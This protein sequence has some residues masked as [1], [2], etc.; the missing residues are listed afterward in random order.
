MINYPSKIRQVLESNLPN[1]KKIELIEE[2]QIRHARVSFHAYRRYM[3]PDNKSG[4]FQRDV[5]DNLQQFYDEFVAG[6]RPKLVIEAPPQH[7]KSVQIVD[8]IAWLS[9]KLPDNKTIY[10]S[11][12]ERLGVRANLSM[13]RMMSTT[14]YKNVFPGTILPTRRQTHS[15]NPKIRDRNLIEYA[16]SLG[17]FRNTTVEGSI[18][19]ESLDL[20]VIDDPMRG[21][22]DANSITKRNSAWD[23]FTD[24]FFTRFSEHAGLL[25]ILTRWHVD[26]PIG[27][28]I[29]KNDDVKVLKYPALAT[30]DAK[31]MKHDPRKSG[32]DEALFPEHKSTEFLLER[33]KT[34]AS[35]NWSALYQQ[36][37]Y[38]AGGNIIKG[39]WFPRYTVLPK[40]KFRACY[41]DTAMKAKESNDFQVAECW[42]KGDDG[43]IYLIDLDRDKYEADELE[44]RF[45]DF[46]HKQKGNKEQG[47][48]RYFGIED[49]AS[50]TELI[51]RMRKKIRPAIPV[52]AI[53]RSVDKYTRVSDVLGYI[54]SGYVVLPENAPWV[55]DFIKE[56]EAFTSDDAHD[57]DDQIDPMCD[58][59]SDMLHQ[60]RANAEDWL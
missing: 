45:P 22:K 3:H 57:Y 59:I 2:L 13:Q 39:S 56:C 11:F 35:A 6:K 47:R 37:P 5:A 42:G 8:F 34:M 32:S 9:G 54:E 24:D 28:L 52:K 60:G 17:S 38:I 27:R 25:C 15:E 55:H 53:P 41:G 51:Q 26:D 20:G 30:D 12:S 50:G 40:I 46:W 18:T 23:W 33:K 4:W 44:R 49:K 19:G 31:L 58:A 21:R 10:T 48:L 14:R 1:R 16:E 43:R 7:G 36:S 29:E